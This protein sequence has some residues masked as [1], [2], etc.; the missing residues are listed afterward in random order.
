MKQ[1]TGLPDI[2]IIKSPEAVNVPQ[3]GKSKYK[4]FLFAPSFLV[5]IRLSHGVI[6]QSYGSLA[7]ATHKSSGA[8]GMMWAA[9]YNQPYVLPN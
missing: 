4:L 5:K 9:T 2:N 3:I 7:D 6:W 8:S 1:L